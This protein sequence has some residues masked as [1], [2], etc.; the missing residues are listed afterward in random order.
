MSSWVDI[1]NQALLLLQAGEIISLTQEGTAAKLCNGK[2]YNARDAVLRAY[3]WNSAITRA[4]LAQSSDAPEWGYD[5]KYA[6]PTDPLCLR[7]LEME[8]EDTYPWKIEGRYLITDN[9]ECNI[10]Y[11]AQITDPND[12]EVLLRDTIATRLAAEICNALA[13]PK[14][15]EGMWKLYQA[16]LREA[17]S[18][19]AQE[20]TVESL[21]SD[22]FLDAR[23]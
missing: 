16:K 6:L 9:S 22:P 7:V 23:L 15:F 17:R 18:I 14:M 11:I 5:Y 13:G 10:K 8:Y 4:S 3:P 12:M 2:I 19:D 20:G 21:M 1:A